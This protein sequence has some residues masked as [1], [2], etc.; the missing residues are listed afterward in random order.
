MAFILVSC[1]GTS[2]KQKQIQ[3][4]SNPI[5]STLIKPYSRLLPT[6][7]Q[8]EKEF[9]LELI[10]SIKTFQN[11]PLDTTIL[12]CGLIDSDFINDTFVSHVFV[13]HDTVMVH[14]SWQRR[15][16]LLW[17][18]ELKYPYLSIS[19]N[20]LFQPNKRSI[21][22]TFTIGYKYA[23]PRLHFRT[24]EMRNTVSVM[25]VTQALRRDSIDVEEDAFQQYWENFKGSIIEFS[26]PEFHPAFCW[27]EPKKMFVLLWVG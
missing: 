19:D 16:E 5:D 17:Q 11:K 14:S 7:S 27:Y 9:I 8:Q 26:D 12:V 20:E 22:V 25:A 2:Q 6:A 10:N 1:S 23:I 18:Y 4:T 3:Q 24:D 15:G 21:W 13:N